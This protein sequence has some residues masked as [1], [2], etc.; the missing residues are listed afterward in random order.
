MTW[1][2]KLNEWW[3]KY[4]H[5]TGACDSG[6]LRNPKAQRS[7]TMNKLSLPEWRVTA[8]NNFPVSER[9]GWYFRAENEEEAKVLARAASEYLR[10]QPL[11]VQRWKEPLEKTC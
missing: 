7:T 8:V 2:D 4:L 9:N 10:G 11:H 1:W 6:T 5:E 3:L